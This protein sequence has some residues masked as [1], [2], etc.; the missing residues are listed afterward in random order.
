MGIWQCRRNCFIDRGDEEERCF[1]SAVGFY[2][3]LGF[4][5]QVLGSLLFI[6]SVAMNKDN[7]TES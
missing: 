2:E 1:L 4:A 7:F 6:P 5:L 3:T